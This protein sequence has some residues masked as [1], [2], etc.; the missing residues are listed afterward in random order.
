MQLLVFLAATL[1]LLQLE[2]TFEEC[3]VN[4]L[5][6]R[7]AIEIGSMLLKLMEVFPSM[8]PPE[9]LSMQQYLE[10]NQTF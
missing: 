5:L 7:M 1:N 4:Q 9:I 2:E 8:P 6:Q 10:K 3:V